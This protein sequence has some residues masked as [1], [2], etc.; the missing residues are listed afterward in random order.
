MQDF[1]P[2]VLKNDL[3]KMYSLI[4]W[5]QWAQE[6]L[7]TEVQRPV[8]SAEEKKELNPKDYFNALDKAQ[9]KD[10]SCHAVQLNKSTVVDICMDLASEGDDIL[11]M[12]HGLAIQHGQQVEYIAEKISDNDYDPKLSLA[13]CFVSAPH[14][15]IPT[16]RRAVQDYLDRI[17]FV[18]VYTPND[19]LLTTIPVLNGDL[20]TEE[21][22][23]GEQKLEDLKNWIKQ[24][25]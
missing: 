3:K 19:G 18:L 24:N 1:L 8:A 2:F 13:G 10:D 4:E 22:Y 5:Y 12:L 6:S 21:A 9:Q 20:T 17:H 7:K 16:V 14:C 25:K 23:Y 11:A 15:S